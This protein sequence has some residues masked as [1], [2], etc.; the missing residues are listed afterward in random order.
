MVV[1]GRRW[2]GA[3]GRVCLGVV[4][5]GPG[6]GDGKSGK[7]GLLQRALGGAGW[8]RPGAAG[9]AGL[10]R[11]LFAMAA[12]LALISVLLPSGAPPHMPRNMAIGHAV[13]VALFA[14]SG[15]LFRH[16][17]LARVT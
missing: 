10:A 8:G 17:G 14:A 4:K 5:H 3:V 1:K 9:A 11:T 16:A 2:C 7:L 15:L 13:Y 12:I 6:C